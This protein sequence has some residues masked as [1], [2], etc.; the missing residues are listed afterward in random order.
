MIHKDSY[1]DSLLN[2]IVGE[3]LKKIRENAGLSLEDLSNKIGNK[4]SRQTLS[5]Y[6]SGRSKI[7]IDMF[8]DICKATGSN[9]NEV[10]ENINLR[11]FKNARIDK[12]DIQR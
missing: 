2:K 10:Y 11:Y 3:E 12:N 8:L 1:I 9:P 7:K 5:T 6:E 4:V